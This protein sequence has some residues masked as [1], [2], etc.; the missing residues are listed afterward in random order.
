MTSLRFK[1]QICMEDG[2]MFDN[3]IHYM[4]WVLILWYG[5]SLMRELMKLLHYWIQYKR[6]DWL[7]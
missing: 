2:C 5:V 4:V 1:K 7:R 3:L 6:E